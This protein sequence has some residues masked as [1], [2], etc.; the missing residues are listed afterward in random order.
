MHSWVEV[1]A[2]LCKHAP[3]GRNDLPGR[4]HCLP[5][6]PLFRQDSNYHIDFSSPGHLTSAPRD[7][8]LH[9]FVRY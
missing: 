3:C 7:K 2:G 9:T 5:H 8:L 1:M 6:I 4:G